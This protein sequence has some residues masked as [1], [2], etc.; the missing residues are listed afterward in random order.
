MVTKRDFE[1][2]A[3]IVRERSLGLAAAEAFASYFGSQN[4]QFNKKRFL[5]ACGVGN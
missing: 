2:V 3:K 5:Q 4:P 1:A